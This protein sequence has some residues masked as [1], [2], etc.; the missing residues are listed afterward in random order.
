MGLADK[1]AFHNVLAN[2]RLY[3]LRELNGGFVQHDDAL[4]LSQQ[5]SAIR[6]ISE[7]MKDPQK[8]L[9][10]ELLGAVA[11]FMCHHVRS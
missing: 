7:E 11:S 5:N 6:L 9:S 1:A 10:D 8:H 3:M 4:I 2:S